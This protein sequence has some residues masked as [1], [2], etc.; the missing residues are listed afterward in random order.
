MQRVSAAV[1]GAALMMSASVASAGLVTLGNGLIYDDANNFT[2]LQDANTFGTLSAADAGLVAKIIAVSPTVT[3]DR[4][5][6]T[7][8]VSASDF[9]GNLMTFWGAE[10]FTKYL[11]SI[12]YKGSSAWA[13]PTAQGNCNLFNCRAGQIYQIMAQTGSS[14]YTTTPGPM[15]NVLQ[16]PEW[17]SGTW[18]D[19][20]GGIA[21]S[22]YGMD[23]RNAGQNNQSESA[24]NAAEFVSVGNLSVNPVPVP[25]S[26]WLLGSGVAGLFRLSRR[27]KAV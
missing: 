22:V 24:F 16:S 23:W 7:V 4:G 19:Y 10:A 25:A 1:L 13:L 15:I 21:G 2:F 17:W 14:R 18:Y 9:S 8:S 27:H 26:V 12:N 5:S 6:G 20:N 3:G 11:N